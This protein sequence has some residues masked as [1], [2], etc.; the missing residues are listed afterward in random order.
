MKLRTKLIVAF[1]LLSVVPLAGITAFSYSSSLRAFHETVEAEARYTTS[2]ME[3]RVDLATEDL[4]RRIEG[5][6]QLPYD[7]VVAAAQP[8]ERE[9]PARR[10]LDELVDRM[11]DSAPLLD[12]LEFEPVEISD[13]P[14]PQKGGPTAP[15]PHVI[16]LS[17]IWSTHSKEAGERVD[18]S[19]TIFRVGDVSLFVPGEELQQDILAGVQDFL[20]QEIRAALEEGT[21]TE[22]E[23]SVLMQVAKLGQLSVEM[24]DEIERKVAAMEKEIERR[25]RL[26]GSSTSTPAPAPAA[27]RPSSPEPPAP[28]QP[29][30]AKEF[31]CE[32]QRDGERVGKVRATINARRVLHS[33]LSRTQTEQGE[34]PFAIDAAGNVYT[35]DAQHEGLLEELNVGAH[36]IGAEPTISDNWAIVTR[37]D[38]NL[39]LVFGIARPIG[40]S[41]E[42]IRGAT[43]RNLFYGLAMI[44]VAMIGI[45]PLSTRMTRNLTELSD[46]VDRLADGDLEAR[47]SVRSRD[48]IGRLGRAFNNMAGELHENQRRL[49]AQ[50]RLHKELEMCRQIQDELLPPRQGRLG[51]GEVR[52]ISIPARELGGDFFNYFTLDDGSL[53][54]LMGDVSGKG[55]PAALLM[56][57]VQATL[58]ARL[59]FQRGLADLVAG[60]DREIETNTPIETYVTLFV[61]VLDPDGR[62]LRYVNAG[63]NTQYVCGESGR[64]ERLTT[65]GRP[66]GLL[67]GGPYDERSVSLEPGDLLCLFTDG[68]TE[69]A[70]AGGAEFGEARLEKLLQEH[71]TRHPGDVV[72]RIEKEVRRHR[73]DTEAADD[74][75]M[76]VLRLDGGAAT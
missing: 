73:G 32:V 37:E 9:L 54:I 43:G 57:N 7:D 44:G 68:L 8:G 50:E 75:T 67:S 31:G 46:G 6:G 15:R 61:C 59:P 11:G 21:E 69:A 33:V 70:D 58:R 12:S 16:H 28:P 19:P 53:A 51:L 3:R 29:A 2:Q 49:V 56:A 35:P 27:L 45:V 64:I 1:L 42:N 72:A 23:A 34:I 14:Q 65:G 38:P 17:R 40:D 52:A 24:S 41:L 5:L 20:P 39:G 63:H 48:E 66:V 36:D 4:G 55:V 74:A 76:L 47:V 62:S 26:R 60:L 18:A 30:F 10:F 13:R 71:T 22:A 25:H